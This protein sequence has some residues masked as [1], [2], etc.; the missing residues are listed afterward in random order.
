M[1]AYSLVIDDHGVILGLITIVLL[2]LGKQVLLE[3]VKV[4]EAL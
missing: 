1:T 3:T 4:K 2:A